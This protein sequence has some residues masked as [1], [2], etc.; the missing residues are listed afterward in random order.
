MGNGSSGN[1]LLRPA[2]P[3]FAVHQ[4][5][6]RWLAAKC[7]CIGPCT[8]MPLRPPPITQR[9]IDCVPQHNLCDA[10]RLHERL[11]ERKPPLISVQA[12]CVAYAWCMISG[13]ARAI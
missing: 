3:A 13:N 10:Q 6:K 1:I 5:V 2:P 4:H 7:A 12:I 8:V 11:V 9:A